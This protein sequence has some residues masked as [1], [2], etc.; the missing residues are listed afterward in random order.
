MAGFRGASFPASVGQLPA[1]GNAIVLS[2]G[3]GEGIAGV[4]AAASSGPTITM[5]THPNDP[6]SKLLIISGRDAVE[7]KRAATALAV[8]GMSLSGPSASIGELKEIAP[9][10]PY[11]APNWL[12]SDRAVKFGELVDQSQLTVSGY[13]P[14]LI[15]VNFQVPPDLFA[16]RK[17]DIPV[18]LK[19]R[20]TARPMADKSTLNVGVNEQ[21]LRALPLRA[22]DHERPSRIESWLN[23]TMPPASLLPK[24]AMASSVSCFRS[25][26]QTMFPKVFTE[27]K[28]RLVREKAWISPC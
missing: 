22:M 17:K 16:W 15:R 23:K 6:T 2:M 10:K 25:R 8:G 20:Y 11:D 1:R 3:G 19:Y 5:A 13:S 14:D 27:F 28:I 7:L 24:S 12:A 18:H 4:P 21:F 26:K 9:R